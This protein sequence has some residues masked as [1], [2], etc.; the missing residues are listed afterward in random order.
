MGGLRGQSSAERLRKN[1]TAL[2][3]SPLSFNTPSRRF[4]PSTSLLTQRLII[5]NLRT[6][7]YVDLIIVDIFDILPSTASK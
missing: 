7:S 1:G 6:F 4:Q 3:A 2:G 5:L